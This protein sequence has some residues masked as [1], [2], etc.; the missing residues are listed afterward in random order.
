MANHRMILKP[1]KGWN[2]T[3]IN[4]WLY[5]ASDGVN[6]LK[7]NDLKKVKKQINEFTTKPA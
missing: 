3:R 2:I 4:G 1:D 7:S 5:V 6:Q